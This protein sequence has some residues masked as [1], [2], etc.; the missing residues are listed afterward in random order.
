MVRRPC[1]GGYA[2]EDDARPNAPT[3]MPVPVTILLGGQLQRKL[4]EDVISWSFRPKGNHC[5][6]PATSYLATAREIVVNSASN[7][8]SPPVTT[9]EPL[10]FIADFAPYYPMMSNESSAEQL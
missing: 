5:R 7:D 8:G 4:T 6:C 2:S 9:R 1:S 3:T 10:D